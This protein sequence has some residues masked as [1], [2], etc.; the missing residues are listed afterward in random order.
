MVHTTGL[1]FATVALSALSAFAAPAPAPAN[2]QVLE[3]RKS[4]VFFL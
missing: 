4:V 3:A 2:V 1:V